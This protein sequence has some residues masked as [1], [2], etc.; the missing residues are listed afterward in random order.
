MKPARRV[1]TTLASAETASA[2]CFFAPGVLC[3]GKESCSSLRA[4]CLFWASAWS[5]IF[6]TESGNH[7]FPSA[8]ARAGCVEQI[9]QGITGRHQLGQQQPDRIRCRSRADR[10]VSSRNHSA[11]DFPSRSASFP[12]SCSSSGLSRV[13]TILERRPGRAVS[14]G[15]LACPLSDVEV[16]SDLDSNCNPLAQSSVRLKGPAKILA[17]PRTRPTAATWET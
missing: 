15:D 9:Q 7:C 17:G 3:L 8:P 12:T 14:V 11:K 4:F 6:S 10:R 13:A 1:R 16:G 2:S 5:R